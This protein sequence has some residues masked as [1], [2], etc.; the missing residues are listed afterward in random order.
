[1]DDIKI[2]VIGDE[3]GVKD[4]YRSMKYPQL[5]AESYVYNKNFIFN[6]SSVLLDEYEIVVLAF[7][8]ESLTQKIKHLVEMYFESGGV[9]ILD[10][11]KLR[12]MRTPMMVADTL[13]QNP[14]VSSYDGI[15]MGISHA[16]VGIIS[17]RLKKGKFVNLAIS[18]QDIYYNYKNLE[19]CYFN[20]F[21]KISHLHTAIIDMYD[22]SYFNYDVSITK[23]II[24]Y[25]SNGGFNR[26]KHNFD[27]NIDYPDYSY[28]QMIEAV[29]N[30]L[31]GYEYKENIETWDM[32]FAKDLG[33]LYGEDYFQSYDQ[34]YRFEVVK[35]EDISSWHIGRYTKE[36][37]ENTLIE[38]RLYFE[39]I[40]ELLHKI[41]P[42]MKI[43]LT[44]LPRY[45]GVWDKE[46]EMRI[47]WKD[48][49]FEELNRLKEK[50]SFC[51][52]DYSRDDIAR[53]KAYYYD[54]AH[55]NFL[56]AMK[57]TDML[58]DVIE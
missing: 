3:K 13:M 52:L 36:K 19:Y 34:S 10:Y 23:R 46:E 53:N 40:L 31:Y 41:N 8:L 38:N 9:I 29:R 5:I 16:E 48:Y 12:R 20:Y 50:Y 56:G 7:E 15:I 11:Y 54:C 32:I 44:L 57:F 21:D 6:E 42:D 2:I 25:L 28:Q 47:L 55:F 14:N 27:K 22:Y 17:E 51:F 43:Y 35:D 26:D 45:A 1:M 30:Q 18:S 49:F 58:N 24:S 33:K 39:K 4:V 37:F